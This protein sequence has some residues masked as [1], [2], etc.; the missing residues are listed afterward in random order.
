M[1]ISA[2]QQQ[3]IDLLRAANERQAVK[4]ERVKDKLW[5]QERLNYQLLRRVQELQTE[6]ERVRQAQGEVTTVDVRRDSHNSGL[7]PP[8]DLPSVRAANAVKRTRSLRRKSGKAVGG[9][10][11]HA[12]ATLRQVEFPDRVEVHAPQRCRRCMHSLARLAA[13]VVGGLSS[14]AGV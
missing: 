11:G 4:L 9:Q 7:P 10:P 2:R 13:V 3:A 5:K 14:S 1:T 8:L 6:L 12:G